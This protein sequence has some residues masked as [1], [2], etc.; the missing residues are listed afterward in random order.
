MPVLDVS[1]EKFIANRQAEG[2]RIQRFLG[3]EDVLPFESDL[4]KINPDS[5]A[6]VVENHEE[7]RGKLEGT[8]FE[9]MLY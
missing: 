1:Y 3:I 7:I 9:E 8:E 2:V 5:M 6:D 4:V